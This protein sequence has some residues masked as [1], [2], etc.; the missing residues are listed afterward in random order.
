MEGPRHSSLDD[1]VEYLANTGVLRIPSQNGKFL[2]HLQQGEI[3]NVLVPK[4]EVPSHILQD[5][6]IQLTH[7]QSGEG[8]RLHWVLRNV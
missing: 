5:R 3:L 2:D 8:S 7:G 1:S 6:N 4:V